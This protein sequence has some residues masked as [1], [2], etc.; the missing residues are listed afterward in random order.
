MSGLSGAL[1]ISVHVSAPLGNQGPAIRWTLEICAAKSV[2]IYPGMTFG[3]VV[4][5]TAFGQ[6]DSY[7][8]RAAKYAADTGID[9]SR[10]NVHLGPR[11]L[12]AIQQILPAGAAGAL[13]RLSDAEVVDQGEV[14][15][16]SIP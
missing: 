15:A 3:K 5:L 14:A 11:D 9:I 12:S 13:P 16:L 7:Q 10:L 8:Q 6:A 2:R 4:F 1:G